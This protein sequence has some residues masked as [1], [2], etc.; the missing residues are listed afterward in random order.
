MKNKKNQLI[1]I[2]NKYNYDYSNINFDQSIDNVISDIEENLINSE[3]SLL[4]SRS[5]MDE[6][7][8]FQRCEYKRN[9]DENRL[10]PE[11]EKRP[12]YQ[13][14]AGHIVCNKFIQ[15]EAIK[16]DFAFH[17]LNKDQIQ[18]LIDFGYGIKSFSFE[19]NPIIIDIHCDGKH[20]NLSNS[21][22]FC[23]DSD[24]VG[25][26]FTLESLDIIE[27]MLSQINLT[28]NFLEDEEYLKIKGVVEK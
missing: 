8:Y 13:F 11:I 19:L 27:T 3:L 23:M 25:S 15:C 17:I 18:K 1:P 10:I 24:I 6:L 22:S 12:Y 28:S 9:C 14:L 16:T 5:L 7:W 2:F 26:K 4:I 20:P 21:K